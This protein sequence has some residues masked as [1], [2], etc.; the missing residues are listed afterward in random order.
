MEM[1]G[2]SL[3]LLPLLTVTGVWGLLA[4]RLAD[5]PILPFNYRPYAAELQVKKA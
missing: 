1:T 5:D 3:F 4:L 2:F